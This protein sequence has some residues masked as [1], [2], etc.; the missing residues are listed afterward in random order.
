QLEIER[1]LGIPPLYT[2]RAVLAELDLADQPITGGVGEV[3][4]Q[5]LVTG[6][7]DLGGQVAMARRRNEEVDVRRALAVAAEQVQAFLGRALRVAAVAR[8]HDAACAVAALGVG[9]DAPAQ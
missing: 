8:R 6:Q 4:P 2:P 5:V 7:V 3:V 9:D 1:E